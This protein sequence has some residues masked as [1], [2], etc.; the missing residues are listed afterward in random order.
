MFKGARYGRLVALSDSHRDHNKKVHWLFRCDCGAEVVKSVGDVRSGH[1]SS[2][3]CLRREVS[4]RMAPKRSEGNITHGCTHT[5]EYACW[6]DM[7]RR[8]TKPTHK[9]YASYGGRGIQVCARWRV[10][11]NFLADMGRRPSP[12]Y[13]LDRINNDG[14]YEPGNCRWA[15][16]VE[17]MRNTRRNHVVTVRGRDMCVTEAAEVSGLKPATLRR[18]V[19]NG[20]SIETAME[21]SS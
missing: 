11:E 16:R 20:W 5:P 4:A 17:Q 6:K 18:R 14:N 10:F 15:T 2:C 1:V 12:D 9:S 3:G 13:S 7:F 8:C 21:R 19:L